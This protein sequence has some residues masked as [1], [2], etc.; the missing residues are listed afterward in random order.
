MAFYFFSLIY[1]EYRQSGL[2]FSL[3]YR[4]T[5]AS[6]NSWLSTPEAGIDS[7]AV[8]VFGHFHRFPDNIRID[9]AQASA[10]IQA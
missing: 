9:F 4:V 6:R 3:S 2:P 7:P 1:A 8:D 5:P 10:N